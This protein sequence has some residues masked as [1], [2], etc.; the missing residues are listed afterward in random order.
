[1]QSDICVLDDFFPNLLTGFRVAEYNAYLAE[2]EHLQVLSNY[3]HFAV[4][5]AQY[6]AQYPQFAARVR[7][8]SPQALSGFGLAYLNFLNNAVMYLPYLTQA[9]L[10]FVMTLFPGGGFGLHE[11]ESDAK[12]LQCLPAHGCARL[13]LL[14]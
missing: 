3:G 5:H 4:H 12:L 9:Q 6:A 10:P 1:M 8:F 7:E 13:W 11:P 14:S 2:F